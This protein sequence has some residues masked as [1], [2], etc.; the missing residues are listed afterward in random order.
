MSS[1]HQ[2]SIDQRGA[3][4]VGIA[5]IVAA[6][7]GLLVL[8][9]AT[10]VLTIAENALFLTFWSLLFA[11]FGLLGG[12]QHETTRAVRN[13]PSLPADAL[14]KNPRTLPTG[15]LIG[16]ALAT[17]LG[18]T[19]PAWAPA[20]FDEH[21]GALV[22]AICIGV[23]AFAGHSTLAGSL[24]GLGRWGTYSWLVGAE[25]GGRL[26]LV[27]IAVLLSGGLFGIEVASA[28]AAAMWVLLLVARRDVRTAAAARADAPTPIYLRRIGQ[29]MIAAAATATIVVGFPVVLK[30]TTETQVY[31]TAAPLLVAISLTRAPLLI[32]LTSYQGVAITHFLDH[33]ERGLSILARSGG[34]ILG[35]AVV[36]AGL[37]A[38][39]GP[40]LM[41]AV[42]GDDYRVSSL[43]LAGL[44][45][46]A[47]LLAVLTLSGAAVLALG[48]HGAYAGG[49]FVASA[50]TL[51]TL[52][53]PLSL[54]VRAT[55]SLASGP[56]AGILCHTLWLAR[57]SRANR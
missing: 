23:V 56:V 45:L 52:F 2:T 33:R 3:A 54:E 15:L 11:M 18:A 7:S 39:V 12:V 53:L 29:A 35:V 5:S 4:S 46:T 48:H 36:G 50:V 41:D 8:L 10:R 49:W 55:V 26:V 20:L 24:S 25:A 57:T 6:A 27:T 17:V 14:A 9:A 44:T 31:V 40:W 38:L 28:V 43:L 13:S 21:Q 22:A 51:L 42:F 47:G 30:L 34:A 37:A 32:P 19:S 16:A 1:S